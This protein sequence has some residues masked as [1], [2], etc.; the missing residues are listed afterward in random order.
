MASLPKTM[1]AV[2][3]TG[4][5]GFE[6]LAW[7]EDVPVPVPGTGEVLI[8]VAAAGMNNTDINTR[9]GWYSKSVNEGTTSEGGKAGLN[10]AK[11]ADAGWTGKERSFPLIQGADVCGHI[12]A[13]GSGVDDARIGQRVLVEPALRQPVDFR[14]YEALYL[15]SEVDGG[16]ADYVKVPAVHAYAVKSPLGDAELACLPCAYS[17][18]ENMIERAG[19]AAGEKVLVTG[20]SG[21]VGSAAVQLARRRGA[22]VFAVTTAGKS[23]E[24]R[25]LGAQEI[26]DRARDL[27]AQLAAESLDVVI[28]VAGGPQWPSLLD[29]L[30]RGGRYAVSG[31]IG[32]P[33]V[34]LDL[35]TLYLKDLRLLGCTVLERQV[36]AN[37]IGYVERGEIRPVLAATYPLKDIVRAQQDFLA[38]A[39]VG[40]LVLIPGE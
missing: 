34:A 25:A 31:A 39:F 2:L 30:K 26:L 13:A 15:G 29:L 32:G 19:V 6:K 8:R 16:F 35:R 40:K 3:L 37:L 18:A 38:K 4:Y 20:A 7:R 21:G 14:P 23:D 12:V 27:T 28:D 17:A 9:I 1:K 5:G 33:I 10:D 24:V 11:A 22:H 36:F